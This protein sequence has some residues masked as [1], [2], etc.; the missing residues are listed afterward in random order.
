MLVPGLRM[1]RRREVWGEEEGRRGEELERW[2]APACS[3]REQTGVA[4]SAARSPAEVSRSCLRRCCFAAK[5]SRDGE[6][7]GGTRRVA[8]SE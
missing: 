1:R 2:G 6:M 5:W 7:E 8:A 3:K 4:A